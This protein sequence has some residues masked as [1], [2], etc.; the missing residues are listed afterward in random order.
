MSSD[1]I[2]AVCSAN[3][4]RSPLAELLL[5]RGLRE[6]SRVRVMSAGVS[7]REGGAIC[8]EVM[9]LG[10]EESWVAAAAAHRARPAVPELLRNAALILVPSRDVRASVVLMAPEVRGRTYMFR[11]AACL[12]EGFDAANQPSH[13]GPVERFAAHLDQAR[14]TRGGIPDARTRWR[15]K[16]RGAEM[17]IADGHGRRRRV[18]RAVLGGVLEA[19]NTIVGHLGGDRVVF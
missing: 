7:S 1:L 19:T 18:H 4:C 5:A 12:G 13:V 3:V 10:D 16:G 15:R 11:E 8:S 2:L 9:E 17:D 14:V 6:N